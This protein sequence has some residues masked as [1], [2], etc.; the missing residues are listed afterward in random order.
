MTFLVSVKE[1]LETVL[2]VPQKKLLPVCPLLTLASC[3][4]NVPRDMQ[5]IVL[6]TTTVPVGNSTTEVTQSISVTNKKLG[7]KN[8][9]LKLKIRFT[10]NGAKVDHMTT[11]SGF[12]ARE[13]RAC[14]SL[15]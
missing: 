11:E 8:L 9:M 2:L 1:V 7:D 4:E 5:R 6:V 14:A 12:P 15:F 10:L 13:Y 3:S